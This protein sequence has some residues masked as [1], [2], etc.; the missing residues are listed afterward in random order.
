MG[1]CGGKRAGFEDINEDNMISS[2]K[3]KNGVH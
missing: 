1:N 2:K 3:I